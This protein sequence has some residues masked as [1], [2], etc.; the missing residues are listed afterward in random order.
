MDYLFSNKER[1]IMGEMFGRQGDK[2]T[3]IKNEILY[4]F[5]WFDWKNRQRREN[6]FF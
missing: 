6:Y 3:D 4:A 1:E 5:L 2:T